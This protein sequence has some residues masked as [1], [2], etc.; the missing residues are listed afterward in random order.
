MT[1]ENRAPKKY[2]VKKK[3]TF[4]LKDVLEYDVI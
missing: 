4:A 1:L 3:E 2:K